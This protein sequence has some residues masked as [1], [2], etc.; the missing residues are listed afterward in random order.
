[1]NRLILEPP[2]FISEDLVLVQGARALHLL[3]VCK[4]KPGDSVKLGLLNGPSG[5]G[6]V[7][8][9]SAGSL[10]IRYIQKQAN[11]ASVQGEV[12]VMIALPRPQ[13]LKKILQK[14]ATFGV[15]KLVLFRSERVE[16]SYFASPVL[17]S[18][19]I[20]KNLIL[21][22]EQGG[23]TLL[24]EVL[25]L[26]LPQ[27]FSQW[28]TEQNFHSKFLLSLNAE[29]TILDH[30]VKGLNNA[31]FLIG[32]EGG[33]IP[34]EEEKFIREGF[35]PIRVSDSILR[36]ESAFDFILAQHSLLTMQRDSDD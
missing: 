10:K 33:F 16:K 34:E 27:E 36:V 12:C 23:S 11:A 29:S 8:E 31:S 26:R 20:K 2:D 18:E 1:M 35:V 30:P 9:S 5:D 28:R 3:G 24:P 17:N 4:L 15:K 22:L 32:P 21:G 6:K 7:L 19:E 13:M 25:V 14:A